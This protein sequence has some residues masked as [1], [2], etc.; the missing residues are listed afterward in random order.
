MSTVACPYCA[1]P[2]LFV[3][4]E[5]IYPHRPDLYGLRFWRCAPCDA[6]VGCHK[7]GTHA[8]YN[9]RQR[10]HDGTEPLGRLANA[11]LRSAKRM[12]HAYF[13]PLWQSQGQARFRSRT[14]AYKWLSERMGL[15]PER[16]HIG[17]FDV[18]QCHEVVELC[19][20]MP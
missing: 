20:A 19:K 13:D 5:V 18:L 6:Y 15:P 4:G 11:Q 8:V 7:A 17:E 3:T 9:G 2:A 12:A 10:K 16:T 1:R 14:L